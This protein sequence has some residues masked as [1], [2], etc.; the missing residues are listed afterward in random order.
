MG[1]MVSDRGSPVTVLSSQVMTPLVAQG[2]ILKVNYRV[3]RLRSCRALLERVIFDGE[4]N[5]IILPDVDFESAGPVGADEYTAPTIVPLAAATG[6]ARYRVTITYQCNVIHRLAWPI[7]DVRPDLNF[8]ITPAKTKESAL[9]PRTPLSFVPVSI[10]GD[11]ATDPT[12]V[13]AGRHDW[14]PETSR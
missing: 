14:F 7:V 3:Y 13:P 1:V 10:A 9:D 6:P 12:A 4:G 11:L 2:G 8:T 5:R